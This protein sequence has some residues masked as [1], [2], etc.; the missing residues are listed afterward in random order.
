MKATALPPYALVHGASWLTP[1][2][3]VIPI[4]SFHEEWI[5]EHE[6][7]AEG[8]RNVCELI[9]RKRWISVALFSEGYLELMVPSK[10]DEAT[11]AM[12]TELLTRNRGAWTK[13]LV[14]SMDEEGYAMLSPGDLDRLSER[15]SQ[16]I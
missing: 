16:G 8:S 12:V 5:R 11:K 10:R 13:A 2:G 4:P 3:E 15:L 9:L 6:E 14:M 1:E 7:L